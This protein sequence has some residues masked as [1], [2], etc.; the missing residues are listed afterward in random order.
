MGPLGTMTASLLGERKSSASAGGSELTKQGTTIMKT[1]TR[2]S[3]AMLSLAAA[4]ALMPASADA[5]AVDTSDQQCTAQVS[6]SEV[7]AGSQAV[8]VTVTLSDNIGNVTGVE[9]DN[10][11]GITLASVADIPR[12]EMAA[13][14]R[15]S[16]PIQMGSSESSW[17]LWLNTS[18]AEEGTHSVYFVAGETR[19]AAEIDV[20]VPVG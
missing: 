9:Q 2:T 11:D 14:E 19:C 17:T 7:E 6:P 1:L 18:E 16:S 10:A 20:V 5:Q 12:T 4:V 13:G 3:G 15:P 8:Q